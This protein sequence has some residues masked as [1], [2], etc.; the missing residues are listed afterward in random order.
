M[1]NSTTS[2]SA[3][4]LEHILRTLDNIDSLGYVALC[5]LLIS[6]VFLVA[7]GWL[8]CCVAEVADLSG[9][10][11]VWHGC[12]WVLPEEAPLRDQSPLE[13]S[14][15]CNSVAAAAAPEDL[16]DKDNE[17]HEVKFEI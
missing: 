9:A 14:R 4:E 2:T 1:S 11:F 17:L 5:I 16:E 13:L 6:C 15:S 10:R 8:L 3:E 12:K 7:I